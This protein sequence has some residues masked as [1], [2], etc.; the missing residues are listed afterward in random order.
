MGTVAHTKLDGLLDGLERICGPGSDWDTLESTMT[1]EK[2]DV[3]VGF[4]C[5]F[6]VLTHF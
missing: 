6:V 3:K 2:T 5:F 1:F 4:C